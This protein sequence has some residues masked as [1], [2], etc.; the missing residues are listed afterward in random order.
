MW[1]KD[2]DGFLTDGQYMAQK[3]NLMKK[4][5]FWW[6]PNWWSVYGSKQLLLKKNLAFWIY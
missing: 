6:V 5:S 4:S 2:F 3:I 1:F